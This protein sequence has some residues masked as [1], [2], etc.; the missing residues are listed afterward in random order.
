MPLSEPPLQV[1]ILTLNEAENIDNCLNALA[2]Q[3]DQRFEVLVV[4]AASADGTQAILR[5]RSINFPVPL[6]LEL[7]EGRLPI[8][9]ARNLGLHLSAA[10][11][12]AF[13]SADADPSPGW[14][15]RVIRGLEHHDMIFG[16]Q[17]HAPK[18]WTLGASVRGLRYHFPLTAKA[19]AL[20]YASN[21][22]AGYRR[23]VLEEFPF[24][25]QANAAEDTLLAKRASRAGYVA[26]YDPGMMVRHHDVHSWRQEM[27]K[28]IREGNGMGYYA[29]ELGIFVPLIVWGLVLIA[30]TVWTV[31]RSSPL[32]LLLVLAAL[33]FPVLRRAIRRRR[34]VPLKPLLLAVLASPVF[35]V[36]FLITYLIGMSQSPP[37]PKQSVTTKENF[38]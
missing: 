32:A 16:R 1:I 25:P 36:V 12:I 26:R 3:R 31:W 33:W 20:P 8:G 4:D 28:A 30:G 22:A 23:I 18:A 24:D 27:R 9:A 21:V 7:S 13:L 34:A 11:Y 14:T 19:D 35:D 17:V 2:Q 29:N 37:F 38:T 15:H 6:R 5:A 10:P